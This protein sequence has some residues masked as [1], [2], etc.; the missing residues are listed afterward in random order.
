MAIFR[1]GLVGAGR[2]GRTH[3]GALGGSERL[4]VVAVT[5]PAAAAR[6]AVDAPGIAVHAD[7]DAMLKAGGLD[8]VLVA[9]PSTLHLD[10]VRR[11]TG[12]GLPIL[13]EKPCG[14]SAAE[15][16]AAAE[17]AGAA[18]VPL[19]IAYWRRFVPALKRLQ[20]RI[21]AGDLGE[22]YLVTCY[23]WD[24]KPPA[25]AFR[26]QSGGI[27]I[28]MGVH[29]FDQVRWLSGQEFATIGAAPSGVASEPPVEGRL[30]KRPA[31]RRALRRQHRFH[32]ARPALSARRRLPG[33]GLRHQGRGRL[34]FP[35]AGNGGG[36]IQASAALAGRGLRSMGRRR[37]G[38][39]CDG[40]RC[41]R[42]A[43]GR[44]A[45]RRNPRRQADTGAIAQR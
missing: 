44:G 3:L 43:P 7:L 19:Q 39:G 36:C 5:E 24:E 14:V 10:T 4:R 1:L 22:L 8:G 17:A 11:I 18:G 29:E 27:L 38:P 26:R 45:G 20:Q 40:R 37:S 2:M 35:L 33:R 23:Q 32:L 28:D 9:A 41:R 42:R 25:A 21:A 12:A 16:K 15:A 34:P 30:R 6:R 31:A 13:C